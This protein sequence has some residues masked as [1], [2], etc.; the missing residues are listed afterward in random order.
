MSMEH[1]YHVQDRAYD[2]G[3]ALSAGVNYVLLFKDLGQ[4]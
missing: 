2:R 1:L 4:N 3:I